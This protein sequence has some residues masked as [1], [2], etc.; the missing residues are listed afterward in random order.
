MMPRRLL[1]IAVGASAGLLVAL[2]LIRPGAPPAGMDIAGTPGPLLAEPLPAPHLALTS[3]R[4]E[5]V[6]LEDFRGR[7][8]VIFFGYTHCPDVCPLTLAHLS[9]ALDDLG[10][11]ADA[12]Q[13]LFV[14]VDPA[15]DT[16][17]VLTRFLGGFHPS[18][19]GLTGSENEVDA[20]A[21]D[22]GVAIHRG[23][24]ENYLVDHGARTF[25][26]DH[27]GRI[28]GSVPAGAGSAELEAGVAAIL[29]RVG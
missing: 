3:H 19:L 22:F 2:L 29:E 14:T 15:R 4:G 16:P 13:V 17:E 21:F 11:R 27:E 24:G 9:R 5:P 6:R 1:Q 20:Q 7:A 18:I 8:V 23:E 10:P 26:L 25:L 12:L 28:A